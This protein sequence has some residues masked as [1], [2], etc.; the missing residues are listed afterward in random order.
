MS[1][2][3]GA[4]PRP[5]AGVP[6]V[7]LDASGLLV[8]NALAAV[9]PAGVLVARQLALQLQRHIPAGTCCHAPGAA[10]EVKLPAPCH[11]QAILSLLHQMH[12]LSLARAAQDGLSAPQ[13]FL[14][15]DRWIDACLSQTPGDFS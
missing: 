14:D 6:R 4:G 2:V 10:V 5:G 3:S 8:G 13:S 12:S 9:C 15:L 11:S 7:A 1:P